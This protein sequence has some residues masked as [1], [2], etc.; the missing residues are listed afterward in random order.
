MKPDSNELERTKQQQAPRRREEN[1]DFLSFWKENLREIGEG[2]FLCFLLYE[3]PE[4]CRGNILKIP[5][6]RER[7]MREE[8]ERKR[9]RRGALVFIEFVREQ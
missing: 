6:F 4:I 3:N 1:A 2:D 5:S 9:R 7:E 8:K